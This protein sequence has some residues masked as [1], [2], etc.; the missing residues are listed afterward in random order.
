MSPGDVYFQNVDPSI[1]AQL[2]DI[3]SAGRG[4]IVMPTLAGS[5]EVLREDIANA[6]LG[7]PMDLNGDGA[8]TATNHAL[9]YTLLPVRRPSRPRC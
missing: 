3:G 6:P 9:D 2:V 8:I 1:Y 5:P 4:E 7:M